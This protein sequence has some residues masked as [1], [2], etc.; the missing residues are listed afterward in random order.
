MRPNGFLGTHL[1]DNHNWL[2][3]VSD[4]P[5]NYQIFLLNYR[6]GTV[7]QPERSNM[8]QNLKAVPIFWFIDI[9]TLIF[10]S[11]I[12]IYL[13]LQF[14]ELAT[15]Y[16]WIPEFRTVIKRHLTELLTGEF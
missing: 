14:F 2:L 3:M 5:V 7:W 1:H 9:Y 16:F 8:I 6:I 4:N 15:K 12:Y 13:S 11:F 10:K